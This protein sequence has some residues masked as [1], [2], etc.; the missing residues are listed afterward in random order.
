MLEISKNSINTR[1]KDEAISKNNRVD[2]SKKRQKNNIDPDDSNL[3]ITKINNIP[4]EDLQNR[5]TSIQVAREGLENSLSILDKMKELVY[6]DGDDRVE[7]L[8]KKRFDDLKEK[9]ATEKKQLEESIKDLNSSRTNKELNK[10][11]NVKNLENSKKGH[12]EFIKSLKSVPDLNSI[13]KGLTAE[14]VASLLS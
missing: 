13:H 3:V 14:K 5:I 2:M 12:L 1:V 4:Y 6:G 11:I 9:L 8:N 10:R 7:I